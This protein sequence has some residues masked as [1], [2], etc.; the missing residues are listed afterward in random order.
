[1]RTLPIALAYADPDVML[2]N[3][4]LISAM[5]HWDPQAEVWC[6]VYCLWIR[7]ILTGSD[8]NSAWQTALNDA[9][10]YAELGRRDE[11]SPGP[12]PLPPD[13]WYRLRYV[14]DLSCDNL[15][16]SGYAGYAVECLEAA[17]WL[18][19]NGSSYEE[20]VTLAVN[21]AGEADTIAA[22]A[23]GAVGA[24]W[25]VQAI[26]ERWLKD[27]HERDRIVQTSFQLAALHGTPPGPTSYVDS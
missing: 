25:G 26:P 22:V 12:S 2:S 19:L 9:N 8:L 10:A 1:M 18:C 5:T 15:L 7:E 23:G 4:A 13:F 27:L 20:T 3:S 6:A 16:P 24:Y 21:L 14:T 17:V 11:R